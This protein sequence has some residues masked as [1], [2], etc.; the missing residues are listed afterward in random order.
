MKTKNKWDLIKLKCFCT[1]TTIKKKKSKKT[2]HRMRKNICKWCD[3][4]GINLQNIQTAHA[5][6]YPE[7]QTTQS[8]WAED[9]NRHF[10]EEDTQMAKRH[11]KRCSTSLTEKCKSKLQWGIT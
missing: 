4:Q 2:T 8:K 1:K 5:A 11:L 6:Q 3:W 9:L 7:K 10:S